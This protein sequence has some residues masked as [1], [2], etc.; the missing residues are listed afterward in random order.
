MAN[1]TLSKISGLPAFGDFFNTWNDWI[2]DNNNKGRSLTVPAV[3]VAED[4]NSYVLN[5]AAP[6]LRKKD[7]DININ[8]NILTVSGQKENDIEDEQWDY[9]RV[10]YNYSSFTRSFTL[11]DD[12][13]LDEIEA[14]YDG[15][16]LSIV[17]PKDNQNPAA[18]RSINIS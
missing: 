11:P 17:L 1:K 4:E 15:G 6:G 13:L 2:G 14:N 12:V 7:F 10:E 8:G 18:G 16:V 9:S 3:N 5:L